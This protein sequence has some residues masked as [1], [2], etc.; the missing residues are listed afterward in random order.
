MDT[1]V[2]AC[3]TI[4]KELL[5]AMG[6]GRCPILWLESGLHNWPDK[7]REEV[8]RLLDGCNGC[9]TVLLAMSLCGNAV[10]G[11]KTGDFTLVIPRCD[12]CITLLLGSQER[13]REW[14]DAYF[15]TEGWL[16]S[17][18]SLWSEYQKALKKFGEKRG[19][20]IFAAMLGHYRHLALVDTG[21]FDAERIA[22]SVERMA[23]ELNLEPVTIPGT[24]DYLKQL[25][26]GAWS[27]ERFL[28][29]P[30]HSCATLEMCAQ[31]GKGNTIGSQLPKNG[32]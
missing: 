4:E 9:D 14:P 15:L 12:D 22:S 25:L 30:P 16:N 32:L 11:L 13:R 31:K 17:E 8:Q 29:V 28:I 26:A 20:Q 19:K 27:P 5:A 21:C 24:L 2:I 7:L 18:L 3:K 6:Q 23:E 10:V 1:V